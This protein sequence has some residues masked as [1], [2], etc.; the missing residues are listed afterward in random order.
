VR[1]VFD[2][3]AKSERLSLNDQVLQ[4]PDLMN[5][6]LG[7]LLR[8]KCYPIAFTADVEA[9]VPSGASIRKRQRYAPLFMVA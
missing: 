6:L 3:A 8:F 7:V 2:C 5:N 1:I 9:H 4:G